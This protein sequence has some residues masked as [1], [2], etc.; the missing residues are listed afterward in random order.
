MPS[1]VS[2][3]EVIARCP[4]AAG[5]ATASLQGVI[6]AN[7]VLVNER[8]AIS[9]GSKSIRISGYPATVILLP[10]RVG[11]ITSVVEHWIFV[12]PLDDTT[13][14]TDDWRLAPQGT[15]IERREDGTH[16]QLGFADEVL[17]TYV[18]VDVEALRKNVLI[19]LTCFDV[20][21]TANT[22]I[23]RQRLGDYE[24]EKGGAPGASGAGGIMDQKNAI[25]AQ[26][27]PGLPVFS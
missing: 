26:L 7:E 3:A 10:E 27:S 19:Q 25:L 5:L 13:L 2:T 15:A 1:L 17:I 6:D 8:T 18:P 21:V 16:P 4:T 12:D 11:S 9:T 22:G 14:A 20:N 23:T 24:E